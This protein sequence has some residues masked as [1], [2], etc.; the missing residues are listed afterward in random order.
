MGNLS[1]EC[2]PVKDEDFH[3]G[4]EP[5][6]ISL[7]NMLLPM[8]TRINNIYGS[9]I[10]D[11]QLKVAKGTTENGVYKAYLFSYGM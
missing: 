5:V 1:K 6:I 9:K 11:Q 10:K 4:S 8:Y 7:W 3:K 2:W